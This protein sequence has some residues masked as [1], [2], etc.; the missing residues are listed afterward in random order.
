[1]DQSYGFWILDCARQPH[2]PRLAHARFNGTLCS[3]RASGR[4]QKQ[5]RFHDLSF[6]NRAS[7][8]A[9]S[10]ANLISHFFVATKR[11]QSLVSL[12]FERASVIA[13]ADYSSTGYLYRVDETS[14][15]LYLNL[16]KK[17]E[18]ETASSCIV[19]SCFRAACC[20]SP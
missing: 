4:S 9:S 13:E 7:I 10:C 1:V 12:L 3:S 19:Q 8:M 20:S 11:V 6:L 5:A 18:N 16:L 2:T 15:L 17:S 14:T